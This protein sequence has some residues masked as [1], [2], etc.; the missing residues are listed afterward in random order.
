MLPSSLA[1][2]RWTQPDKRQRMQYDQQSSSFSS[3]LQS[4]HMQEVGMAESC[5]G[6]SP[7]LP[8]CKQLRKVP[9]SAHCQSEE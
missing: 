1:K 6:Q 3:L 7:T 5:I 2:E 4:N 9:T 8:P